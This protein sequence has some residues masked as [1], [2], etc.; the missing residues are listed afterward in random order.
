MPDKD[1][2][3]NKSLPEMLIELAGD[4]EL[5][6]DENHIAYVTISVNEHFEN[7]AINSS[8]FKLW[9]RQR[10]WERHQKSVGSEALQG[11][12]E[13]LEA[14]ATFSGSQQSV[15]V[16][17]TEHNLAK[18]PTTPS[19]PS[20]PSPASLISDNP[21]LDKKLSSD[22]SGDEPSSSLRPSRTLSP[23]KP[24]VDKDFDGGD[25]SDGTIQVFPEDEIDERPDVSDGE[26]DPRAWAAINDSPKGAAS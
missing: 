14:R 19:T 26:M 4:C 21:V 5:F 16:R 1:T 24:Y 20:T 17:L 6:H 10:M 15:S 8:K 23:R 22:G 9:V 2:N 18:A 13:S 12:I 11:A 3:A 7:Y 25:E